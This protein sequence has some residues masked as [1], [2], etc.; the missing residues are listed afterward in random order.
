MKTL[1]WLA[2]A[3][4]AVGFT[5]CARED[6]LHEEAE[7]PA[8]QLFEKGKG[9]RLPDDMTKAFGVETVEVTEKS[10]RHRVEASGKVY[11]RGD[12]KAPARATVLLSAEEAGGLKAGQMVELRSTTDDSNTIS[13]QLTKLEAQP[14]AFG[15]VEALVEFP[16]PEGRHSAG[17]SVQA[18]FIGAERKAEHAVPA[19]AIVQSA[20][21]PFVYTINGSHFV[22][23]PIRIGARSEGWLE[24]IDGLYAGDVIV[25]KGG[26]KMWMIELCALKGGTPCCPVGKK[27]GRAD[28]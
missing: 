22:R 9:L 16:D 21:A 24:V 20:E 19:S 23:T 5:G 12:G 28:D 18:I 7:A 17:A 6:S 1:Y 10:F 8:L 14:S 2:I 26:E 11:R 15:Q 25:A 13:G 3:T 27:P 4:A